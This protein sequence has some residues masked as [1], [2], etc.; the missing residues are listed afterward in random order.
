VKSAKP[1]PKRKKVAA[2]P[3]ASKDIQKKMVDSLQAL[4]DAPPPLRIVPPEEYDSLTAPLREFTRVSPALVEALAALPRLAPVLAM[5]ADRVDGASRRIEK[6][7]RAAA[8]ARTNE[9][10]A[11]LADA[12]ADLDDVRRMLLGAIGSM[13]REEDYKPVALQLRELASVSPSLLEWLKE[14]P[15][16]AA[17]LSESLSSLR[18]AAERVAAARAAVLAALQALAPVDE[19]A[20]AAPHGAR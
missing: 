10:L 6:S 18:D 17:P 20:A 3:Q 1:K 7:E 2:R 5:A 4:P 13:P 15:K 11:R 19:R 9:V 8:F 12:A 14:V 16:F